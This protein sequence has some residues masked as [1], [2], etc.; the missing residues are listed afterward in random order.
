[1]RKNVFRII[2]SLSIAAALSACSGGGTSSSSEISSVSSPSSS[3]G[4]FSSSVSSSASISPVPSSEP[5]PEKIDISKIDNTQKVKDAIK[6]NDDVGV[7]LYIPDTEIDT[8][9]LDPTNHKTVAAFQK[10]YNGEYDQ[11][12][13]EW[14]KR[15]NWKKEELGRYAPCSPF[16]MSSSV[17]SSREELSPNLSVL[18]YNIGMLDPNEQEKAEL[19][20]KTAEERAAYL[21][22]NTDDFP[23]GLEFAQL[24]HY[25]DQAFMTEHPYIVLSTETENF[26][27]EVFAAYYI[28]QEPELKYYSSKLSP[29]DAYAVALQAIEH[30]IWLFPEVEIAPGDKFITLST[31][32]YGYYEKTRDNEKIKFVVTGRLLPQDAEIKETCR[33]EKNPSPVA[34]VLPEKKDK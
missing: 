6:I 8:P 26:I 30:S 28:E 17:Y 9:V 34:P 31:T 10:A 27:Y 15:Y 3:S 25:L 4:P 19:A 23:E 2:L 20:K 16:L 22:E 1:M 11:Q 24:F 18:G 12:T 14:T 21:D 7:Y 5:E 29:E 13:K 33:V 32:P